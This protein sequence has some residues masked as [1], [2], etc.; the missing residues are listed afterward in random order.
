MNSYELR[1]QDGTE[2]GV[3]AC[4]ACHRPHAQT[5][6][7]GVP[8]SDANRS[9]A[10]SCCVPRNCGRCGLPTERDV[11]GDYRRIHTACV[12][13]PDPP[14]P[15]MRN[16]WAR[17]LFRRMSDIS[18]ECWAAAWLIGNEYQL[19]SALAGENSRY[20]QCD[21]SADDIEELRVLSTQAQGWIWTGGPGVYTPQLVSVDTWASLVARGEDDL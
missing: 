16:P 8:V 4:G 14:H 21:L 2:S 1:R 12:P 11:L 9:R 5:I 7:A 13:P 17:L 20:G 18:E 19:W 6:R 15:S 3:W 10:E